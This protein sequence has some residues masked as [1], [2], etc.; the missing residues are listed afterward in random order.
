MGKQWN[1]TFY[2]RIYTKHTTTCRLSLFIRGGKLAVS[3]RARV[4]LRVKADQ[5]GYETGQIVSGCV[6][7]GSVPGYMT[8]TRHA[9]DILPEQACKQ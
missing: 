1:T 8:L 4:G 2:T 3:G 9:C 7:V 5:P 6:R